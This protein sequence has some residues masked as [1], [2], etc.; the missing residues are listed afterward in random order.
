MRRGDGSKA[1]GCVGEKRSSPDQL[2]LM[3]HDKAGE[4]EEQRCLAAKG[5]R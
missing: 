3:I 5:Q 4:L 2:G 1:G